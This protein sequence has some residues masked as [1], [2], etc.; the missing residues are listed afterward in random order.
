ML[1]K[2][3]PATINRICSGLCAALELAAQHDKRVQNRDGWEVGLASLPEAQT[4]RLHSSGHRRAPLTSHAPA[5][6]GPVLRSPG[7]AETDDANIRQGRRPESQRQ[8]GGALLGADHAGSGR[9]AEDRPRRAAPSMRRFSGCGAREPSMDHRNS[10]R[11]IVASTGLDPDEVTVYALRHSSIVRQ[12]LHNVPL[13]ASLHDT[14]VGQ[15]KGNYP[16][17]I[18]SI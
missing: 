10:V 14:W 7:R 2:V 6:R 18:P 3:K 15:I 16:R 5:R 17:H 9:E 11:A 8:E 1:A 13:I 12:L 4:A